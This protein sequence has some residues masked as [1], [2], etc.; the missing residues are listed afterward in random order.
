MRVSPPTALPPNY[1]H[2]APP[3]N[4]NFLS[5]FSPS[6]LLPPVRSFLTYSGAA[7]VHCTM[8]IM[9]PC[10]YGA[11]SASNTLPPPKSAQ[12]IPNTKSYIETS[13]LTI[14]RSLPPVR[15]HLTHSGSACVILFDAHRGFRQQHPPPTPPP[16]SRPLPVSFTNGAIAPRTKTASR[17][18]TR[19]TTGLCQVSQAD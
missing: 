8:R 12:F 15:T 7:Y 11:P 3:V 6:L 5:P 16:P 14:R 4:Q 19:F 10:A 2:S 18:K 17:D 1:K 9:I 13:S